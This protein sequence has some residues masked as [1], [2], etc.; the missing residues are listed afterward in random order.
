MLISFFKFKTPD[1]EP[2]K[3]FYC[4]SV[5][6]YL[7]IQKYKKIFTYYFKRIVL[8]TLLASLIIYL[9]ICGSYT[10]QKI[11]NEQKEKIQQGMLG[12][13]FDWLIHWFEDVIW[14]LLRLPG[15][16]CHWMSTIF[17][18]IGGTGILK[19]VTDTKDIVK[20]IGIVTGAAIIFFTIM[21][22][23]RAIK[24]SHADGDTGYAMTKQTPGIVFWA[25]T[26]MVITPV[27][28]YLIIWILMEVV[29]AVLLLPGGSE[30]STDITVD[31][32]QAS[33]KPDSPIKDWMKSWNGIYNRG[34]RDIF[35][36]GWDWALGTMAW[37]AGAWIATLFCWYGFG[38]LFNSICCYIL[39]IPAIAK[40][41]Q[42]EGGSAEAIRDEMVGNF[43]HIIFLYAFFGIMSILIKCVGAITDNVGTGLDSFGKVILKIIVIAAAGFSC[44]KF[45][46]KAPEFFAAK[47]AVSYTSFGD[48]KKAR[49]MAGDA[50]SAAISGARYAGGAAKEGASNVAGR[51]LEN[52]R[53]AAA[54]EAY[55]S[56][57]NSAKASGL[58][59]KQARGKALAASN[60]A[61]RSTLASGSKFANKGRDK[62][63][64]TNCGFFSAAKAGGKAAINKTPTKK[65]GGKK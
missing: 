41:P 19:D 5:D 18:K 45:S 11:V 3:N 32:F 33:L 12:G 38:L 64:G 40:W 51:R 37:I 42:D 65:S 9:I 29:Q 46:H 47:N 21:M 8:W 63:K 7:K 30:G 26:A 31:L 6:T 25:I 36:A 44:F 16:I 24:I 53:S 34:G 13:I 1:Y 49:A 15:G 22:I 59:D 17:L 58:T 23:V 35:A 39:M 56:A 48:T 10:A 28:W 60:Q 20:W 54:K 43:I 4:D 55:S 50:A 14:Y 52:K 61:S 27:V 2:Q 62:Y 57:L